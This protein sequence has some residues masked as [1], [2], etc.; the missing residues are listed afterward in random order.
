MTD[1]TNS[2]GLPM[3]QDE[4]EDPGTNDNSPDP[5][6]GETPKSGALSAIGSKNDQ[7]SRVSEGRQAMSDLRTQFAGASGQ[8]SDAYA[9]QRKTLQDATQRLLSMQ[10]GPTPQEAAYRV[11]AAWGTGEPG[12]GRIN[13]GGINAAH[14]DVLKEQR[15][16]ELT[17]Q[18]LITQYGMQ[19]PQAQLGAANSNMSRIIQ[20]MRIQQS[21]NN[22]ASTQADKPVKTI[23]KYYTPDPSD[24]NAPPIFNQALYDTDMAATKQKADISAKAKL[25]AQ[26]FA[27]TGLVSPEMIDLG[28]NDLKSLPSAI[29]RSPVAM[30][31]I[32]H[33]IHD[34]AQAEGNNSQSFWADQQLNKE[35][36]K[37][38]D[39]YTKGKTHTS[40]DGINTAVQHINVYRPLIDNLANGNVGIFN[41]I[42]N[43]W[44][45]NVMGS[46]APT[47]F[48][49][50]RDFVAGEIAK[51]V[52]PQGGGEAERQ[53]LSRN[54][55]SANSPQALKSIADKWQE[56]L[57]G[58]TKFAKFNWDN[59]TRG[60]YGSFESK[61]LTPDTQKA[62][63]IQQPAITPAAPVA[64]PGQ[65][66]P[67][68]PMVQQYLPGGA[69]YVG[70]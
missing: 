34:R 20:E 9:Q 24:P 36:S 10:Y 37:V 23:G 17:K 51:A 26:Q 13:S 3:D 31:Q 41:T 48:N 57:A 65:G 42:G 4:L 1:Q 33:G 29:L 21:D 64:H 50:V 32:L 47:D 53:E 28:Y 2:I 19:V 14:A 43:F 7:Q 58:K 6:I 62:L 46:P 35:S 22:N 39:D 67:I 70:P 18:Q 44:N 60:R 5:L 16:G 59:A 12:T 49:G 55:S 54:A 66:K 38:L 68:D 40:L 15:Q 8:A 69:K 61:F 25:T 27:A 56:L 11:A 30:S 45:K 63:G 52:L